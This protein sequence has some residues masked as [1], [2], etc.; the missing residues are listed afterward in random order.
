MTASSDPDTYGQLT[1]YE[2][3]AERARPARRPAGD[4][5]LDASA[6]RRSTRRS[7]CRPARRLAGPLRRP[8]ARQ[9]RRRA[10]VGAAVLRQRRA[11]QSGTVASVTEYDFVMAT[12]DERSAY[13]ATLGGALGRAVPRTRTPTSAS[14]PTPRSIRRR[15]ARRVGADAGR[16]PTSRT[17]PPMDR[18]PTDRRPADRASPARRPICSPRPTS[19]CATPTSSSASTATSA[20]TRNGSTRRRRSSTE[21]LD[22]ARRRPDRRRPNRR[23]A[24]VPTESTTP[25]A[26]GLI[27]RRGGAGRRR[28]AQLLGEAGEVLAEG[29]LVAGLLAGESGL[30]VAELVERPL[31]DRRPGR[32]VVQRLD[33]VAELGQLVGQLRRHRRQPTLEGAE[34]LGDGIDAGLQGGQSP[35]GWAARASSNCLARSS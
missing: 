34:L 35:S 24:S 1:V 29:D 16:A 17:V 8:P 3:A 11:G 19:C 18:P 22:A 7:R 26:T 5:Q 33:V 2:V 27:V 21:A 9:H 14:D 13:S 10:A 31:V 15:R 32:P 30:R 20:P 25:A 6:S 23:S 28:P 12:Y 4:R